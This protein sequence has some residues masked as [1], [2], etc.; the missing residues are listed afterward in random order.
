VGSPADAASWWPGVGRAAAVVA[1]ALAGVAGI[2]P[3]VGSAA[4]GARDV[5]AGTVK[6]SDERTSTTWAYAASLAP[7]RSRPTTGARTI[8]RLRLRTELGNAESYLVLSRYRAEGIEWLRIRVP[9]R[10]NGRIGWVSRQAL[11]ALRETNVSVEVQRSRNRVVVRRAGK[12]VMRAPIG[13]GRP[14]RR[15]PGGR[16]WI[17]DRFRVPAGGLYGVRA[18]GTSAYAPGLTDWP[19][20]GI[21]GFHGTDQPG[22]VPGRP[23]NGCIRM[24][25]EDVVR[26]YRLVRVGTP[27]WI[28]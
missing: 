11:G 16:F 27:I 20:G 4:V 22:L 24:R 15:T 25:N 8:S 5:P 2:G 6:L 26:F 3:G 13:H 23:S 19:L 1:A 7:I 18:L 12:V 28:R 9:G 10:P 14:G 21:V 17:R